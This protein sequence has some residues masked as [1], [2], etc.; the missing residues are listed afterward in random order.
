MPGNL[1]YVILSLYLFHQSKLDN[2]ALFWGEL[3]VTEWKHLNTTAR[4]P[5]VWVSR[6][7]QVWDLS[8]S[9]SPLL[10]LC[11]ELILCSWETD[12]QMFLSQRL[13]AGPSMCFYCHLVAERAWGIGASLVGIEGP[14]LP[15]S[16]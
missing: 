10:P 12:P 6:G 3:W 15:I 14:Q 11:M 5:E 8:L 2:A 16:L 13:Q 4:L 9:Q 1:L 7:H